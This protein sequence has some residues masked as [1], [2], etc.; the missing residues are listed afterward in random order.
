MAASANPRS[1]A[2]SVANAWATVLAGSQVELGVP[3]GTIAG[4]TEIVI[5]EN[6]VRELIELTCP[7]SCSIWVRTFE[8]AASTLRISSTVV[9]RVSSAL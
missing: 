3:T 7:W 6:W 9:A 2:A 8:S 5:V 4:A 1:T